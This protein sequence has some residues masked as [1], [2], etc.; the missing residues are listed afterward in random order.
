MDQLIGISEGIGCGK[1]EVVPP[2]IMKS[3][4]SCI[5]P[6]MLDFVNR[7]LQISGRVK[8]VVSATMNE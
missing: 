1:G 7:W 6:M 3:Y 8:Y 5:E 2:T 4:F